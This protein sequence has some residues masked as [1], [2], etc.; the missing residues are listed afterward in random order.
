MLYHAQGKYA[1]AEPL[2]RRVLA[3]AEKAPGPEHPD[4]ATALE[5]CSKLL[6]KTNRE[7]EA[8]RMKPAPRSFALSTP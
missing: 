1:E 6:R 5:N 7:T 8:V 2:C 4:V 3:I